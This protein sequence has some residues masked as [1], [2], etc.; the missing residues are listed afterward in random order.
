MGLTDGTD[1]RRPDCILC[2]Q[3]HLAKKFLRSRGKQNIISNTDG[4]CRADW[5]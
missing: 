3:G 4:R 5:Y 1:G 2:E